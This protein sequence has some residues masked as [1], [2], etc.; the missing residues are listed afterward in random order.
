MQLC[1][2]VNFTFVNKLCL[3]NNQTEGVTCF[4]IDVM[5]EQYNIFIKCNWYR[6]WASGINCNLKVFPEWLFTSDYVMYMTKT[7]GYL[8][9]ILSYKRSESHFQFPYPLEH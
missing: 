3:Q 8:N 7:Y 4:G 2:V 6:I 9:L 1:G 5:T